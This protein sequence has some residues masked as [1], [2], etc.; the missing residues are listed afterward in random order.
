MDASLPIVYIQQITTVLDSHRKYTKH[1]RREDATM[2][3]A[4]VTGASRGIGRGIAKRLSEDGFDVIVNDIEPQAS[5]IEEVVQHI[6]SQGRKAKGHAADVSN[7]AQVQGL[8]AAAVD[9]FGS[10][11]V[12]VANAG[13][14]ECTP[15]LELSVD[16][17]DRT[18]AINLRGVF[19]C[20]QTAAHQFIK[21][22]T[23]GK[24]IGACSIS[25]Y[26][27]SGKAPA[28]C[29]SKWGVR[30]LTQTAALELG[31]HGITVNAYCP[32]SVKTD[33]SRVFAER[34]A[35][36]QTS[37]ANVDDVYKS[38]SHRKNALN[39]ELYP[40]DIAGLVSFLA[41]KDS[42]RM[43]GQTMICDG[44]KT[45]FDVS[46]RCDRCANCRIQACTSHNWSLHLEKP[47]SACSIVNR[48][49]RQCLTMHW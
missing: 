19:L 25:G 31:E 46:A 24:L 11:D 6:A 26:R 13:I 16:Q 18:M 38:S 42:N 1:C 49:A 30:G 8:V 44:G 20:Y 3:V 27:P 5:A 9:S 43:T 37:G 14:L 32:G 36:E 40:E 12:M 48:D 45:T 23:G 10:L 47:M 33:M 7:Q 22:G 41:S 15:L 17:F 28:Y 2:P 29:T 35:K 34:L 4:I 39:K 21:Q